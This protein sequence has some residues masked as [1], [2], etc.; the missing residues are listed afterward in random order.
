M[1]PFLPHPG[2]LRRRGYPYS[3]ADYM[4]RALPIGSGQD[5]LLALPALSELLN[6]R[7]PLLLPH[8][9]DAPPA[10]LPAEHSVAEL[11]LSLSR[12]AAALAVGTSGSTG[13]AKR[14]V[15]SAAALRASGEATHARLGGAGQWLLAL[16]GHHIAG[17]QV[18]LR[19]LLA[20]QGPAALPSGPFT[21]QV[22]AEAANTMAGAR[23]YTSLVPTQL[24]R[25]LSDERARAALAQFDAVL[26][27][28]SA[29]PP[30]LVAQARAEGARIV[31]TY[32]MSETAGGCVYD[33]VPL[34]EVCVALDA[35]R[36]LIAGPML[37][38]GYLGAP[39]S[40][41]F[42]Q[43][44]ERRWFRT[45]DIG[46]LED[47]RLTIDGRED[48]VLL[49]GGLKVWPSEVERL[50][51][52]LL[53]EGIDVVV[54]GVPDPEWGTAVVAAIA[55]IPAAEIDVSAV[56][57]RARAYLPRHAVP[58]RIVALQSLPHAGP[59]KPDRRRI[60]DSIAQ[61]EAP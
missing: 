27:G 57:A 20:G 6:G 43:V 24:R 40:E 29:T 45:D 14:A 28:G 30:G 35:G 47:G 22:F 19:S 11:G 5:A 8:A 49:T 13:A 61:A 21:A 12:D 3:Y 42:R 33:G 59:G 58:R 23:R 4:S 48:D 34:A 54:L 52:P 55:P 41:A 53:P 46:H 36:V 44:G 25:V 7:G 32:G 15:L 9:L 10:T 37:A 16:P 39:A 1:A 2:P 50:L 17:L 18:L 31:L 26:V 51:A 38:N 60:A 56:L